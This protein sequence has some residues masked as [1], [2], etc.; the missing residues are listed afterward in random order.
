MQPASIKGGSIAAIPAA[1]I[2]L[3]LRATIPFGAELSSEWL[4]SFVLASFSVSRSA[5]TTTKE[6]YQLSLL[7]C[8]TRKGRSWPS[9]LLGPKLVVTVTGAANGKDKCRVSC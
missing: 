4:L 2:P 5:F 6:V 3:A 9:Y 8:S 7:P 1:A